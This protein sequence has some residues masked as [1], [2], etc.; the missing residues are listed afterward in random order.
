MRPRLL[1]N[2]LIVVLALTGCGGGGGSRT[3]LPEA[4]DGSSGT[5]PPPVTQLPGVDRGRTV[6]LSQAEALG[7]VITA[8]EIDSNGHPTVEF[9]AT[10]GDDAW[11][12]DIAPDNIRFTLAKLMPSPLGNF[13]G[14]W[15]SYIN[16]IEQPGVGEGLVTRLQATAERGSDGVLEWLGDG[17][18]RYQFATSVNALPGEM[19]EQAAT[20]SIDLGYSPTLTHR[21][22][23]Q[24]SGAP[25]A[26]N[27]VIDFVP[28]TGMTSG[29]NRALIVTT[30]SCNNCHRR[31]ALHGGGRVEMDYCVT[32]HNPGTTD[33]NSTNNLD[34]AE[35]IHRIHRGADL[36]SVQNGGDYMIYGFRDRL[37]DYSGLHYPRDI[38]DC[39]VCH[40]GSA[41]PS[42]GATPT[43]NG[44]N[45]HEFP[46]R[47][48][49]GACHD[50]TDFT[51]HYGG[52]PDD[53]RCRSCHAAGGVAGS[54]I[55][56][57]RDLVRDAVNR[58]RFEI[59]GV[60]QSG[61]GEFPE[62]TFQVVNPIEDNSPYDIVIDD[63][64]T[65]GGGASR[66]AAT[67]A[68]STGDYHNTGNGQDNASS[69]SISLPGDAEA[70]GNGRYRVTSPVAIPDGSLAPF[71]PATGSGAVT[72]EGHPAE[73]INDQVE[74]LP[75]S[76][77]LAHFAITDTTPVPR[78]EVVSLPKCLACHGTL[79]LH[80]NNRT[81][82]IEGC[83]TCHNPRNTDRGVRGF[84][85]HV[86]DETRAHYP[87]PLSD[88]N[89][90]HIDQS[91]NLPLVSSVLGTTVNTGIDRAD[92]A[93][94]L[95]VS[96][97]TAVC[98]SCH[99]N[100]DAVTHMENHGGS[101]STSQA[102][103]DDGQV[104]ENCSACHSAGTTFD[105]DTVHDLSL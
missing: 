50:D 30:Q 2:F 66:L 73:A 12:T 68:W 6:N 95:V 104:T 61:P 70:L 101:F 42:S 43:A 38:K 13:T 83:T 65:E 46:A 7:V 58:Y 29:I 67:I 79:S 20:E 51:T 44:D 100:P 52:Q 88:C 15:Q 63:A 11:V 98:A 41:T 17:D 80:G 3:S 74:R 37:H 26:V 54:V 59:T 81:D 56:S 55:D 87:A 97:T 76:N 84:S 25:V 8:A 103:M 31:L 27:P 5:T 57:H 45:W 14:T 90:C 78:R 62:I 47:Q 96:P 94:D 105:V 53:S 91:Y 9:T 60:E 21:V 40:V 49:C 36:P 39:T 32:C 77:A 10:N 86:F 82:N 19:L 64:F 16:R 89:A 102:A 69:V 1:L 33:A 75:V 85:T 72:L 93:D 4:G 24:I 34:M 71:I 92:P 28:S 48:P 23:M 18:Y 99:D 22:A 35:M